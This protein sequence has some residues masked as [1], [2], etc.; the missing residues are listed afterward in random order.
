MDSSFFAW[1]C[2]H[3]HQR[4]YLPIEFLYHDMKAKYM[5]FFYPQ[6]ISA[7]AHQEA[8]PLPFSPERFNVGNYQFRQVHGLSRLQEKI[9]ILDAELDDVVIEMVKCA[10]RVNNEALRTAEIHF[11]GKK[12]GMLEFSYRD[13]QNKQQGRFTATTEAYTHYQSV[14]TEYEDFTPPAEMFS[15]IN[16]GWI[17]E[18]IKRQG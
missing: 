15:E 6:D 18:R 8:K 7:L 3:C 12:D 16:E 14:V 4:Y 17:L 1:E 9:R 13:A 10:T 5:L 11:L 2:P